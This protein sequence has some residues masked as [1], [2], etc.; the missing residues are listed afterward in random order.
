MK[1]LDISRSVDNIT[2]DKLQYDNISLRW[3]LSVKRYCDVKR[4]PSSENQFFDLIFVSLVS[5]SVF[6]FMQIH[7]LCL[8]LIGWKVIVGTKIYHLPFLKI[9]IE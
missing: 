4:L 1:N 8:Q 9:Y 6:R 2:S 7:F 5:L 3:E